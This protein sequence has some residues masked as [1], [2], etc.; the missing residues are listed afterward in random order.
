MTTPNSNNLFAP[1]MDGLFGGLLGLGGFILNLYRRKVDRIEQ[2][3][4]A[5]HQLQDILE[6]MR[7]D[8]LRMHQENLSSFAEMRASIDRV[9][10]N[11]NH[12]IDQF[13]SR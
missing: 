7:Q 4:V 13:Y 1:I 12:R 11:V 9:T 3:M 8:Y 10:E 6:Q 5:R 2:Q